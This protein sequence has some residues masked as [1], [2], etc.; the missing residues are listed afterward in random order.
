[1]EIAPTGQWRAQLPHSTPSVS[2]TQLALT[3]T[4]CPIWTDDLSAT[5]MGRMAPV[6]HTSEHR[7][8]SGRQYPRSYDDSG[9]MSVARSVD[10]RNTSLGQAETQS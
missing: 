2:G 3:Q 8:H 4:A 9:C 1:M 10:G 6:G 5:D 7:V